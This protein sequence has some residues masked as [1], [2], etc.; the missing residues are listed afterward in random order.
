M[1]ALQW[2][3]ID[4]VFN[5]IGN[6]P[7]LDILVT[8]WLLISVGFVRLLLVWLMLLPVGYTSGAMLPQ[9]KF[10]S[11]RETLILEFRK[12][13]NRKKHRYKFILQQNKMKTKLRI[14]ND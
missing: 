2:V 11:I 10:D 14:G 1:I 8:S 5:H 9:M 13:R 12:F 6:N 7:W 4:V 3:V